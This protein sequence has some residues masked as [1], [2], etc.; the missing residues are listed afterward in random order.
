MNSRSW[1]ASKRDGAFR[2][3]HAPYRL[4]AVKTNDFGRLCRRIE[5][6][7]RRPAKREAAGFARI[8]QQPILLV[9]LDS[10]LMGVTKDGHIPIVRLTTQL[11]LHVANDEPRAIGGREADRRLGHVANQRIARHQT[12]FVAFVIAKAA[13]KLALQLPQRGHGKR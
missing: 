9:A 12:D 6:H 10:R 7:N 13:D 11:P 3:A 2:F 1:S 4:I 8:D 5:Q